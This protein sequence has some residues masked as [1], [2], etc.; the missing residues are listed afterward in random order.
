VAWAGPSGRVM[1][2]EGGV[3]DAGTAVEWAQKIGVVRDVS[4]LDAFE[5]GPAIARGLAFV[6]ALSGLAC[7]H[8]DRTAAG[9][10]I[11]MSADTSRE[12]MAQALLEGIAFRTAEV[13]DT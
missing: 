5:A 7:P 10:W 13:I 11:G 8:W 2:I 1:A 9:L 4:E 12:D 3:Y 6:P